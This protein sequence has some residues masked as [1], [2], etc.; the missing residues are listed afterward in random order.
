MNV[1]SVLD[2]ASP[3]AAH[4]LA[5]FRVVLVVAA[6]IFAT[7]AG[8]VV[9][10][11]IR[12]RRRAAGPE[13][14]QD[15][16]NVRLELVWT[17]IP[18]LI[19]AGLFILTVRAMHAID[20]PVHDRQ[21]DLE[22]VAHQWWWEGHYPRTGVTVANEFHL[23]VGRPLLLRFRS[24]DVVHDWWVPQLGRKVDIFP[25]HPTHLWMQID[26]PGTYQGMCDE[27]CGVEHAWMRIRVV[28]ETEE[29]YAA[30]TRAQLRDPAPP[31]TPAA[32]EG[33][34]LFRSLTC[35]NCH[36]VQGVSTAT[37]GPDLTHLGGRATL[38]AGVLTN[39]HADLVR[40]I[41]DP[42]AIKPG[43]HMPDEGL[44]PEQAERI[45]TYLE[46]LE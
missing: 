45:A 42:Q 2:P 15:E 22:V 29:G 36:A 33:A 1:P 41:R 5:L 44:D 20:P 27:F 35:V 30:W 7:V 13:P 43:C 14:R 21:P 38:G 8:L 19:L 9:T 12:F 40:W 26:E 37:V 3:E 24:G 46:G 6:V 34:D 17:V 18:A 10:A 23:P 4:V 11:V 25:N 39:D 28:G 16:G 31:A 32:R